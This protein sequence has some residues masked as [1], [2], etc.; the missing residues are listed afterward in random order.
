[1]PPPA[2][3]ENANKPLDR[4]LMKRLILDRMA[5]PELN[6]S[7]P[8]FREN[9][10]LKHPGIRD[11]VLQE[12][13]N[14]TRGLAHMSPKKIAEVYGTTVGYI[15]GIRRELQLSGLMP[16]SGEAAATQHLT[17]AEKRASRGSRTEL[18]RADEDPEYL[19][20]LLADEPVMTALDRIKILSRLVRLGAPSVKL[21]AIKVLEDLTKQSENRIGPP[22]PLTED[23]QVAHLTRIML[24][25]PFSVVRRAYET[26]TTPEEEPGA[27]LSNEPPAVLPSSPSPEEP[28]RDLPQE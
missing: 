10:R 27:P 18:Q 23:D 15:Y 19:Q 21:Q 3:R 25:V 24:A 17:K 16:K 1:M 20:K 13:I 5:P 4:P 11:V 6:E 26:I 8:I 22:P 7:G 9:L 14:K 28:V 12:E 2:E